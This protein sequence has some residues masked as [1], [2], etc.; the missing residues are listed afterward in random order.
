MTRYYNP[1]TKTNSTEIASVWMYT[2]SIEA[3]NAALKAMKTGKDNGSASLYDENF[4]RYK[5]L[6]KTL[7]DNLEYYAGTYTLTSY[8]QTKEWTVYGVNRGRD[9]GAAMGLYFR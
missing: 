8:T 2:S 5:E 9:K 6:L 4:E 1:Y 3:V 7:Y